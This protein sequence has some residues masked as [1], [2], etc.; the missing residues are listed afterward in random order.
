M[1]ESNLCLL[2]RL[3]DI[4]CHIWLT[5]MKMELLPN[6]MDLF[7][8]SQ[9]LRFGTESRTFPNTGFKTGRQAVKTP[10]TASR[11]VKSEIVA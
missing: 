1:I 7:V 8:P 2:E 3:L 10:R 4:D 6:F 5:R 11:H 9:Q